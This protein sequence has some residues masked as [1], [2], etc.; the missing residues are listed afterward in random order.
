MSVKKHQWDA[1]KALDVEFAIIT[2]RLLKMV[3]E[4]AGR[5]RNEMNRAVIEVGLGQ[6]STKTR[7]SSLHT[8]FQSYFIQKVVVL[9][10]RTSISWLLDN[11]ELE[12]ANEQ[13]LGKDLPPTVCL[14]KIIAFFLCN[15]V[16]T[17]L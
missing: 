8:S 2:N 7:L 16:F 13:P 12:R 9:A 14:G 11:K 10:I 15:S 4:A 17:D 3:G 5:P 1:R 6:F